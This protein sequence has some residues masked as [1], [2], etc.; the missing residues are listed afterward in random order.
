M[1]LCICEKPDLSRSVKEA[2]ELDGEIFEFHQQEQIYE[3]QNYRIAAARGHLFEL[4]DME[5]YR[6]D[7]ESGKKYPWCL[8]EL[9]FRPK[10]FRLSIK[11]DA[12]AK[13]RFRVIQKYIH[14]SKTTA[15]VNC[16]DADREGEIIVR[17]IFQMANKPKDMP[18]YRPWYSS[19]DPVDI[20]AAFH[21]MKDDAVYDH[22]ASAGYT[23]MYMDW[24]YGINLTRYVTLRVGDHNVSHVGRVKGAIIRAVYDRDKEIAEFKPQ[25]YYQLESK[26]KVNGADL[27][28]SSKKKFRQEDLAI[29]QAMA[30]NYNAWVSRVA[31]VEKKEKEI[32][33]PKLYSQ[34]TLQNAMS[35]LYKMK[36][37]ETLKITQSLYEKKYLTYPRTSSEYLAESEKG[38]IQD[39]IKNLKEKG[40]S[41]IAFR[42]SKQL[43]DNKKMSEESH[44]A[45][46]PTR[47]IPSP[48]ELEAFSEKEK[49]L[50][51]VV[52]YR[53][54]AAFA[55]EPC[56]VNETKI[57]I[58]TGDP[59]AG[60]EAFHLTGK[61][62]ITKGFLEFEDSGMKDSFLPELSPGQ[63]VPVN[64][65]PEEKQTVPPKHYTI[66]TLNKFLMHPFT[67][68]D[69]SEEEEYENLKKGLQIGTDATRAGILKELL[70]LEYIKLK[71]TTY[72]IT[73]KGKRLCENVEALG[74]DM[75]KEQ[76]VV[77]QKHISAVLNGE[78]TS[79]DAMEYTYGFLNEVI[80]NKEDVA[81]QTDASNNRIV[82]KC[83]R[84][85]MDVLENAKAFSCSSKKCG[86][87]MWK[88]NRF[89][90][91]MKK[92]LT[93]DMAVDLL[94]KKRTFVRGLWSENKQSKFNAFLVLDD[95]YTGTPE[96]KAW[97]NFKLEFK[98]KRNSTGSKGKQNG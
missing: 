4:Y 1:Y 15:I 48:E 81:L 12:D 40:F 78:E 92:K 62:L 13:R 86:F 55:E 8:E 69:T 73:D 52:L 63:R 76:T 61:Q 16:G 11:S 23:R 6:E 18:V 9:P 17:I 83:P 46:T 26:S 66:E 71:K 47:I 64:F 24:V 28:L 30:K 2:L 38:R 93:R 34:T 5:M 27:K 96:E 70:Q 44:S 31:N 43:F 85:G 75:S 14:D 21:E 94:S 7:Y 98:E 32:R 59:D 20:C 42:D 25:I 65:M 39:T 84:C 3:S 36:P 29:A 90:K 91:S 60:G 82:G 79:M 54:L 95:T 77:F 37:D 72:F 89:L 74:I 67:T 49:E 53:F 19:Q 10:P 35:K 68:K 45:I 41:G 97:V 87:V 50:Y 57:I 51:L 58:H 56:T 80:G 22:L 88:E 33:R